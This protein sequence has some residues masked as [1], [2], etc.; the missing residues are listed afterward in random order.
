MK[1]I[2]IKVEQIDKN[3]F[4]HLGS[5]MILV[6]DD[7]SGDDINDRINDAFIYERQLWFNDVNQEKSYFEKMIEKASDLINFRD[8]GYDISDEEWIENEA[9]HQKN[10]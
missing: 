10:H 6:D 4:T 1:R 3:K 2:R 8:K 9:N 5:N 7:V